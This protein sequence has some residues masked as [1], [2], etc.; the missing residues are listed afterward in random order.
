MSTLRN[1]INPH[2]LKLITGKI[3]NPV[4]PWEGLHEELA[5]QFN[6][7]VRNIKQKKK[8]FSPIKT[9]ERYLKFSGYALKH[10]RNDSV[11]EKTTEEKEKL[12]QLKKELK[13]G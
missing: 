3:K 1:N 5:F 11:F 10:K 9:Q 4:K 7:A 2:T 8:S 13:N 12:K 6:N